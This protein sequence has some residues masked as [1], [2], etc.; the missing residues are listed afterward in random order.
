MYKRQKDIGIVVHPESIIHSAV[1]FKDSSVIA[2]MGLPDMKL[3]IQY[4]LFYPDRKENNLESLDLFKIKQ[5]NFHKPDINTF[6]CLNLAYKAISI[7]GTMPTV[8]NAA[9]EIAVAKFLNKE[10]KFLDIANYI[11]KL[12]EQHSPFEANSLDDILYVK[13]WTEKKF[14]ELI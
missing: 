14:T 6:K 5:L 13:K 10:I 8:L 9:N 1:E 4:A 7:G 2:Q 12:M 11:E 3:P